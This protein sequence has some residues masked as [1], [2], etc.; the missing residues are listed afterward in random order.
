MFV[1]DRLN[2]ADTLRHARIF[3]AQTFA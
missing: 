1:N 3:S 2:L